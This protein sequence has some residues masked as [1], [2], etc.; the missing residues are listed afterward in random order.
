MEQRQ[1][2]RRLGE[3]R[4]RELL[5]QFLAG[6]ETVEAFCQRE[7]VAK[8]SF[9]RWRLRLEGGA[10]P[11]SASAAGQQVPQQL[12]ASFV[13][14]GALSLPVAPSAQRLEITLD[15]GGGV[16]LRVARG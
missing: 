2:R 3:A 1:G 6:G 14:L 13:E 12:R 15:L 4:W 11:R 10:A 7:G 9:Q 5:G 8:S 16:T